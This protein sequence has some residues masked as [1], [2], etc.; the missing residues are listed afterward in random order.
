MHKPKPK[1][2][3]QEHELW[4]VI[5]RLQEAFPALPRA[6]IQHA[7]ERVKGQVARKD[8]QDALA[9]RAKQELK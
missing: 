9:K 4:Y 1:D 3:W 7:V 2:V 8:G 6:T 5:D